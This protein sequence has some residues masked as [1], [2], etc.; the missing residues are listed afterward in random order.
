MRTV[1]GRVIVVGNVRVMSGAPRESAPGGRPV[2]A[3][4]DG[5]LDLTP[6]VVTPDGTLDLTPDVVTPD[7]SVDG[8]V[9]LNGTVSLRG[10][11]SLN[12]AKSPNGTGDGG[13]AASAASAEFRI[14]F[15][16]TGNIC[17][18]PLA[19]RLARSALAAC[20]RL[21]VGSA[22]THAVPGREMPAAARRALARLGGDPAG[23]VS[24]PL[25]ADLVASADLV[26][27][28]TRE[29]RGESVAK[30][31]PSS[32]RT[33]TI[34][35]FGALTQAVAAP[36]I[37]HLPD[38]VCR[39]HALLAEVRRLRGLVPVERPDIADPYGGSWWAHRAAGRR[40][41]ESLSAPL[42]LL[43]PSPAS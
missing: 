10:T 21:W 12:G 23:F 39:A 40:I 22:G 28:A 18:S 29:Q 41:A 42:R 7:A 15:V 20:P 4:M 37:L 11:V 27:T 26:L 16:C 32:D 43:T 6:D 3:R 30:H 8:T 35:E 2:V 14:L 36:A 13:E 1:A 33:F 17:R 31:P 34:V 5:T 19:E 24:R 38:P 9:S 25:T